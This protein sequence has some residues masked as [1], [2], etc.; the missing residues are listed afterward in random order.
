MK[1]P[2]TKELISAARAWLQAGWHPIPLTG[3]DG[4]APAWKG[5]TGHGGTDLE[6]DGIVAAFDG[7]RV[8]G[9]GLRMPE[10]VL[11]LDLDDYGPK[12]GTRSLMALCDLL[13]VELPDAPATSGR[14]DG[15]EIRFFRVP[16]GLAWVSDALAEHGGGVD[17]I[18]RGHRHAKAWPSVHHKTGLT[19]GRTDI[20][21][22]EIRYQDDA[23][24]PWLL[25]LPDELPDLPGPLVA[26][27]VG[28]QGADE[29]SPIRWENEH[30]HDEEWAPPVTKAWA[31]WSKRGGDRY[32]AMVPAQAA[33]VRLDSLGQAGASAALE[34][35]RLEYI[36]QV[37]DER[38]AEAE[39]ARALDGAVSKVAGTQSTAQAGTD[40]VQRILVKPLLARGGTVGTSTKDVMHITEPGVGINLPP[41]FWEARGYL[42]HIRQ[43][44][45]S[46][47]RSPDAVLGAVLARISALVPPSFGIPAIVGAPSTLSTFVALVGPSGAGKSSAVHLA[48][49]LIETP[50]TVLGK[51]TEH[52][53]GSGEGLIELYMGDVETGETGKGGQPKTERQQKYVG[54]MVTLDEGQALASMGGRTGS[55]MLTTMRTM[56]TGAP[57]G[58]ANAQRETT[59][60]LAGGKYALGLVV[61]I[62]PSL[63]SDLL[64]DTAA[65][66]PQRFLWVSTADPLTPDERPAWPGRLKYRNPTKARDDLRTT[67]EL[68]LDE[69]IVREVDAAALM[70]VRGKL[71][72]DPL[73]SHRGLLKLKVAGLLGLLDGRQEVSPEDWSLA[74]MVLSTSDGVRCSVNEV[75]AADAE[76]A[77]ELADRREA[78]RARV[79]AEAASGAEE[80]AYAAALD[81]AAG[82]IA[83]KAAKV[84]LLDRSEATRCMKSTHRKL[85]RTEEA[86]DHA[87]SQ[88]WLVENGQGWKPGRISP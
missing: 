86:I 72:I 88:G 25:P 33:L 3:A 70:A 54:A 50:I 64:S 29:R 63:A 16:P 10:G 82:S 85:V 52:G 46:R 5:L 51:V 6:P 21:R 4:K 40:L 71:K 34:Q 8:N 67:N 27:L 18:H 62:Q 56:W 61:G 77:A 78:R 17:L 12:H 44:A 22:G 7:R 80:A 48:R 74:E 38:D 26:A 84:G 53:L 43:A 65:G 57:V 39:W 32:P 13:A 69:S 47:R 30:G 87:V 59:R 31:R 19:Y 58:Q 15:S 36:D 60:K 76:R 1:H 35:L 28:R 23:G 37:G 49:D 79:R 83:R 24:E 55:T 14:I 9:L 2:T 75:L 73:D 45:W 42:A 20:A 41:E 11:G 81:S 66:T 68:R